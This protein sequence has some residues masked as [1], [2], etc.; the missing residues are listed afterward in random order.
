MML[1]FGQ[2]ALV[3]AGLAGLALSPPPRGR[4]LLI[5]ITDQGRA[6]M[7]SR[8]LLA[9]AA[10]IARGPITDSYV[11]YGDRARIAPSLYEGGVLALAGTG[12]LCGAAA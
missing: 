2:V 11:V 1:V 12:D 3:V 6:H 5:P 7:L 10:V 8:A 9:G 4:M